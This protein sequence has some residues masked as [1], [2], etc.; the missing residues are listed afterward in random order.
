MFG[1]VKKEEGYRKQRDKDREDEGIDDIKSPSPS[2]SLFSSFFRYTV[3]FF[4]GSQE[5]IKKRELPFPLGFPF[6]C[7]TPLERTGLYNGVNHCVTTF[8]FLPIGLSGLPP[9]F[10]K[11][12]SQLSGH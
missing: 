3:L 8:S 1:V 9:V 2:S 7:F 6:L 10:S 5:S 11:P 12:R 4:H